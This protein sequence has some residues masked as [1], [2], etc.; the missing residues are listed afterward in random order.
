[1]LLLF[2]VYTLKL[3]KNMLFWFLDKGKSISVDWSEFYGL[4]S[5]ESVRMYYNDLVG[6]IDC[7]MFAYLPN[8]Y[9]FDV[10]DNSFNGKRTYIHI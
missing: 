9:E 3:V 1:M 4:S 10:G 7:A 8:L 6:T 2:K 5:L